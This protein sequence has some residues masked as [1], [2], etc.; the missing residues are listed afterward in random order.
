MKKIKFKIVE[1]G[2]T[3]DKSLKSLMDIPESKD[4]HKLSEEEIK[5]INDRKK[6]KKIPIE[7]KSIKDLED[8]N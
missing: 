8:L 6:N 1:K 7:T 3:I 5:K 2:Y 4:L